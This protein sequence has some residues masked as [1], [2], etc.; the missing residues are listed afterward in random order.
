MNS[1][2]RKVSLGVLGLAGFLGSADLPAAGGDWFVELGA[3]SASSSM[4]SAEYAVGDDESGWSASVGYSVNRYLSLQV[5]YHDLGKG[6]FATDCPAPKV[7][8]ITNEDRVDIDGFSIA[9]T[10]SYPL[11]DVID[12][13]GR[14][15]VMSW[16]AD[17]DV[18]ARDASDEDFL[19]GVGVGFS[20]ADHWRVTVQYEDY[21]FDVDSTSVGISRRFGRR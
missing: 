12:V 5:G 2:I 9:A 13:F 16:D 11:T 18:V 3:S 20:F 17:F 14:V 4:E 6:H 21:G 19:Y 10:G 1:L 8:L 7:C 15:G